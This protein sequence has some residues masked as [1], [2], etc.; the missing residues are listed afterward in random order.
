M[1]HS[2]YA[3]V[4]AAVVAAVASPGWAQDY[5]ATSINRSA[6]AELDVYGTAQKTVVDAPAV[7][8]GKALR[9]TVPAKGTNPWDAGVI[10]KVTGPVKA[11]DELVYVVYARLESGDNGAT[12]AVLPAN[13]VSLASPPYTALFGGP[14]TI[15]PKWQMLRARWVADKDYAAGTLQAGIQVATGKQ[16]IDVGPMYVSKTGA[17]AVPAAPAAPSG[18]ADLSSKIVND[19]S[20]PE[21]NGAKARLV[22][23]ANIDGG[24]ALRVAVAR[25][26]P[27]NWA[28]NVETSVNKPVRKG[29]KLVLMFNARLQEG[30]GGAATATIP[31]SA[32]QMK[33]APYSSLVSGQPALTGEWKSYRYEGTADK[34]HAAGALKASIQVGNAKQ[35]IDFGPIVVLNLGQ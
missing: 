30:P 17:G 29:D 33:A 24:K 3:V 12:S 7:P 14:G 26:G 13:T 23:D 16:V 31:H 32:I 22:D 19:P 9:I 18:T 27:N 34:D 15:G 11:G 5:A 35:T 25:K 6:V 8:G 1:R 20:A 4:G 2:G 21:V 10:S 28:S